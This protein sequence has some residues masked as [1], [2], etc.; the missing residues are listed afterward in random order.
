MLD[1]FINRGKLFMSTMSLNVIPEENVIGK[2]FFLV[3][4]IFL[5]KSALDDLA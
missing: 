5:L 2:K 1:G 3:W 4:F